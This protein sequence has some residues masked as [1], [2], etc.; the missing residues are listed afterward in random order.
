MDTMEEKSSIENAISR[1]FNYD[2]F[3]TAVLAALKSSTDATVH[4]TQL[5]I[6]VA[7]SRAFLLL[8]RQEHDLCVGTEV[9]SELEL[10]L[11]MGSSNY[12]A[13]IIA[14]SLGTDDPS[15]T[16][17][18]MNA[19]FA[20]HKKGITIDSVQLGTHHSSPL[21]QVAAELTSGYHA[22]VQSLSELLKLIV[23]V[24][25]VDSPHRNLLKMPRLATVDHRATCF[26]HQRFISV[27]YVCSVCLAVFCEPCETCKVCSVEFSKDS[28]P[29][30]LAQAI[31]QL[32]S[33]F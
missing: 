20:C 4:S 14:F 15:Q 31:N 12:P 29:S 30:L 3:C 2:K 32:P 6:S 1:P 9:D 33:T 27:G 16:I 28:M 24:L 19:I 8:N 25:L 23:T 26:C 22:Q 21:L 18:S 13:R 5:P 10:P 11:L 7:L 17:A